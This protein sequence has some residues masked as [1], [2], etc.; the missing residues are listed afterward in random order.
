MAYSDQTEITNRIGLD[1]LKLL[2]GDPI[3]TAKVTKAIADADAL[4]DSY[5]GKLFSVPLATI[6]AVIKAVSAELTI[7]NLYGLG[8]KV[9]EFWERKQD[10]H[11]KWLLQAAEGKVSLGVATQPSAGSGGKPS[12]KS[13]ERVFHRDGMQEY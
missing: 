9:P 12:T 8:R 6:P 1:E 13:D 5:V 11:L 4:I 2:A 10:E 7:Y 3:D